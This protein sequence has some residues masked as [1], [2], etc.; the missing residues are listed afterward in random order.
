DK[1]NFYLNETLRLNPS[2]RPASDM[3][4]TLSMGMNNE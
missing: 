3:L 4:A 2:Y 1:S